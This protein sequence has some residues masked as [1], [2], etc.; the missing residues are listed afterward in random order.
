MFA[1]EDGEWCAMYMH[2]DRLLKQASSVAN[3][4]F[5]W[6]APWNESASKYTIS[7]SQLVI[8]EGNV[9]IATKQWWQHLVQKQWGKALYD[10]VY[11]R[12][13]IQ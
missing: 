7:L 10:S 9:E 11:Q 12:C 2:A 3:P 4:L 1:A 6:T 13:S 8:N 5:H